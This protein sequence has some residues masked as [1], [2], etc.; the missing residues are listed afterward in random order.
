MKFD[1]II[2]QIENGYHLEE[3]EVLQGLVFISAYR[4]DLLDRLKQ[5]K[6]EK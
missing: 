5:F 2:K 6:K 1:Q 4:R 3:K